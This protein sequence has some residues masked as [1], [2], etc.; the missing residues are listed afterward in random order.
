MCLLFL[1]EARAFL[2]TPDLTAARIFRRVQATFPSERE[3]AEVPVRKFFTA[4]VRLVML[5]DQ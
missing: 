3:L 1:P 2:L 5:K 4:G